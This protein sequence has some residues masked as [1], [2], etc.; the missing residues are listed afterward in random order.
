[1]RRETAPVAFPTYVVVL[2]SS[3]AGT[4]LARR[5]IH[6]FAARA[7]VFS[8][9]MTLAALHPRLARQQIDFVLE[10]LMHSVICIKQSP[11][12]ANIRAR[13]LSNTIVQRVVPTI[14]REA[15]AAEGTPSSVTGRPER[16]P[17][18]LW[19]RIHSNP[20]C[21]RCAPWMPKLRCCLPNAPLWMTGRYPRRTHAR[22]RSRRSESYLVGPLSSS[23]ASRPFT[24]TR[25]SSAPGSQHSSVF[26]SSTSSPESF[27]S[28]SPPALSRA[29]DQGFCPPRKAPCV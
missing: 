19:D 16:S 26:R 13:F 25:S 10:K 7:A 4:I 12:P 24:A 28:I 20:D 21:G 6:S 23:L 17:C 11:A 14:R 8:V 2:L 27:A 9:G 18:M 3:T 1:M 5:L 22:P 15:V 29:E